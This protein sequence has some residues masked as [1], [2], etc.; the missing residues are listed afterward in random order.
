MSRYR[1]AVGGNTFFFTVVTHRRRPILCE[2]PVIDA[3]REAISHVRSSRPFVIDGFVLLP[4]HLH[5]VWTL[6]DED[7]DFSI[8]WS[9]IKHHVSFACRGLYVDGSS[10]P[11]RRKHRD[12][13]IWQRRFWEHR[14]RDDLDFQRHLDYVHFNPVKHGLVE[15]VGRWPYS[16]FHRYVAAGLYAE[17]WAGDMKQSAA[18]PGEMYD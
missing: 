14:I 9:L 13:G 12:G 16:T 7:V 17:D 15:C 4:D 5:C 11:S 18:I 3:L 8:R 1:R 10:T 6:P 2:A